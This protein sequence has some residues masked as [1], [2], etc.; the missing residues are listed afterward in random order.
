L[1]RVTIAIEGGDRCWDCN[2]RRT[3]D[4]IGTP[5]TSPGNVKMITVFLGGVFAAYFDVVSKA[6]ILAAKLSVLRS[7]VTD[8]HLWCCK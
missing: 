5:R 4:R 6:R 1:R 8:S 3:G 2:F 7:I